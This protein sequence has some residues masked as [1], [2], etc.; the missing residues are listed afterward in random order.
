MNTS[1]LQ[2]FLGGQDGFNNKEVD[3]HHWSSHRHGNVFG[4]VLH[5][6]TTVAALLALLQKYDTIDRSFKAVFLNSKKLPDL[7]GKI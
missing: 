3:D 6:V 7:G 2:N 1:W 4:D 5:D